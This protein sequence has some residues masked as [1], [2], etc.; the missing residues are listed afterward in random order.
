MNGLFS[1]L[2]EDQGVN[3]EETISKVVE[4]LPLELAVQYAKELGPC[5]DLAAF[6]KW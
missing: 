1:I 3:F 4:K 6:S 5:G 2:Q